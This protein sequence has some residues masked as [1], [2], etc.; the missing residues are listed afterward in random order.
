MIKF[1]KSKIFIGFIS[2]LIII[3]IAWFWPSKQTQYDFGVTFSSKYSKELGLDSKKV[4]DSITDELGIKKI[5]LVAYWDEIEKVK[6]QYNFDDLDWQLEKALQKDLEVILTVGRRVPRWP[7]C[8]I[9]DWAKELSWEEEKK[10]LLIYIEEVVNR[11]KDNSA[12]KIWQVENE[13]FLTVYVPE[14][15]GH[16]TDKEF[17]DQEI[18]LVKE[19]DPSRPILTTDS[20]NLGLWLSA[21]KRGDLFGSTFYV[22]LANESF[23]DIKTFVNHNFYKFKRLISG[24]IYDKKPVYLIEVSMEPWLVRS[25]PETPIDRQLQSM[26]VERIAEILERSTKTNF[27]EQYLWGVEWWYYLRENDHPEIWNYL[28]NRL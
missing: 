19:I 22:Y 6:D 16:E 10:E 5:R 26:N 18:K 27:D 4:F 11:Y 7:E 24:L 8:H 1:I 17:F 15:C 28:K 12:I 25:I 23:E 21:Y 2:F 3:L 9:P 13:P 20:G 14:I